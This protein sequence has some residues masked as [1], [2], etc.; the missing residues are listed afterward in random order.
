MI[1]DFIIYI[2]L[3]APLRIIFIKRNDLLL[4]LNY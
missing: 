3:T 4:V 1:T 2:L